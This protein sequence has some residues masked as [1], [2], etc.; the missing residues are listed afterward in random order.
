VA[1][2]L[3]HRG[4]EY[5]LSLGKTKVRD[6]IRREHLPTATSG[7]A[8]R[9]PIEKFVVWSINGN[10]VYYLLAAKGRQ[11]N[12][13]NKGVDMSNAQHDDGL[14]TKSISG[15]RKQSRPRTMRQLNVWVKKETKAALAQQAKLEQRP[16][17]TIVEELIQSYTSHQ[18]ADLV[19]SQSLPLIREIVVIEI[20]KA[21]AQQR[22]DLAEDMRVVLLEAVKLY[23]HQSIEQFVR[24]AGR[25]IRVSVINRRLTLA[26]MSRAYGPEFAAQADEDA[27]GNTSK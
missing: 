22:L 3:H 26:L 1:R 5:H 13:E 24:M 18:Q 19:E 23:I 8:I 4:G 25:A 12:R 17:A 11:R 6:L 16:M 7:R 10:G 9:V 2:V 14:A 27:A 21:L 15:K 20:R